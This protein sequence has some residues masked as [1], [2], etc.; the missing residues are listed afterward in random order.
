V[1]LYF[2]PG[3]GGA[4]PSE[5]LRKL[6]IRPR[7]RVGSRC[8]SGTGLPLASTGVPARGLPSVWP[9]FG[10]AVCRS[11]PKEELSGSAFATSV[12]TT[13]RGASGNT[14][15]SC[16]ASRSDGHTKSRAKQGNTRR[17]NPIKIRIRRAKALLIRRRK[18][19]SGR[20]PKLETLAEDR[21]PATTRNG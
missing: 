4:A 3:G 1:K 8:S 12:C 15:G 7:I 19:V 6:G 16:S 14:E 21:G 2:Q 9:G 11:S 20:K 18:P 17:D 5:T 13:G 10:L